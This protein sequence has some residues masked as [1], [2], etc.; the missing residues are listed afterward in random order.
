M[1]RILQITAL[2]LMAA[3]LLV[4]PATAGNVDRIGTAGAQELRIPVGTRGIALGGATVASNHGIESIYYNPAGLGAT[5][6][7][8][9]LFS[10]TN[11]LADM[12]VRY[13]A[14][15]SKMSFGV[16]G[17]TA[18]VLDL[19]N[20]YVTTEEAPDGTG[21][22]SS[23]TF[24]TLGL[25]YA[26]YLT[27]AI[28]F[29]GTGYY[30]NESVLH[31]SAHGL[32]FD[33]GLHYDA[34]WHKSRFGLVMKNVGPNM[35]FSGSDLEYILHIP[36]DDP[37]ALPRTVTSLSSDFELPSYF[38][39]GGE[40]RAWE[41]GDNKVTAY[42]AFQSNNFSEDEFRGGLEFDYQDLLMLRG[43]YAYS[44]QDNYLF[45]P[46]FGVG[47]ILPVSSSHIS[48][49]YALQT[50]DTWFDDLHTFSAKVTF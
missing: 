48:V 47:L 21:E 4:G 8:E 44:N 19:G 9:A 18:K 17:L 7:A 16:I 26:R 15:A 41:A 23:L 24:A 5:L 10:N 45:G 1:K 36:G 29:G 27:D 30:L 13:F 11:Y 35:R 49:D 33:L 39:M 2:L 37:Q 46:S 28:C 32:A 22:V 40:I 50:V 3:I 14:V 20:L 31:T 38:Q 43:G 25:S 42:G 34:G 6:G 12:K